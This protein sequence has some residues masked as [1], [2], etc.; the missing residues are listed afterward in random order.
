MI[1]Q[2]RI[3]FV[4]NQRAER[5]MVKVKASRLAP[6][7]ARVQRRTPLAIPVAVPRPRRVLQAAPQSRLMAS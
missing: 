2:Y 1:V 7:N 4:V 3:A 5:Q 6:R